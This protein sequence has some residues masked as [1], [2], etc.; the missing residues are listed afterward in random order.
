M[1]INAYY[2]R[3]EG[4]RKVSD[5]AAVR[6]FVERIRLDSVK[7]GA[8][9]LSQ[10]YVDD[11]DETPEFCVGVN[12]DRGVLYYSGRE[13]TGPW[14]SHN[15]EP[16]TDETIDYDYMDNATEFSLNSEIPYD[17]VVRAAEEFFAIQGDRPVVAR[18]HTFT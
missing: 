2:G 15:G 1:K 11:D 8:P 9:L 18:W 7:Y 17:E 16:A 3:D 6:N 10:W 12:G 13:W 14:S 4:P 5:V